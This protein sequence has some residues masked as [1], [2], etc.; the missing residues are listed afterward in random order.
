MSR[1]E[2]QM[3]LGCPCGCLAGGGLSAICDS[4]RIY[5]GPRPAQTLPEGSLLAG[6]LA[7]SLAGRLAAPECHK[8]L[9]FPKQYCNFGK[10]LYYQ[11]NIYILTPPF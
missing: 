10:S 2:M 11:R 8:K 7:G 6:W 1:G 9:I 4:I 5:S 3:V